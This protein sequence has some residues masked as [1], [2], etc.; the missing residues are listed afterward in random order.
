MAIEPSLSLSSHMTSRVAMEMQ[1]MREETARAMR[2]NF[3][4]M[5]SPPAKMTSQNYQKPAQMKQCNGV[6]FSFNIQIYQLTLREVSHFFARRKGLQISSVA[7]GFF[8]ALPSPI[9]IRNLRSTKHSLAK[10]V[11]AFAYIHKW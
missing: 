3:A 4:N 2:N 7:L 5:M 8:S 6:F 9:W 11:V 1:Q 10:S